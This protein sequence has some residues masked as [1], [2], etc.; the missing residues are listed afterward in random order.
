MCISTSAR[1]KSEDDA[2]WKK[3][4]KRGRGK[5]SKSVHLLFL[6]GKHQIGRSERIFRMN[7]LNGNERAHENSAFWTPEKPHTPAG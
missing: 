6:K 5:K 4:K 3:K 2:N 1:G 7:I